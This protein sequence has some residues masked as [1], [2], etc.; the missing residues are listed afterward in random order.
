V[1]ET[2]GGSLIPFIRRPSRF[3]EDKVMHAV[4]VLQERLQD[5][6]LAYI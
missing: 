1:V 3:K 6:I 5:S 4:G 2:H